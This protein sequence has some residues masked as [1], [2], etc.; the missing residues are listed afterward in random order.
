LTRQVALNNGFTNVESAYDQ[1]VMA[2]LHQAIQHVIF[3]IK[4]NRTYDQILGD[5]EIGNGDPDLTEFGE[6]VTPNL[7]SLARN[8]VTLD[9]FMDTAEVSYDG[10]LWTTS[11]QAPDVVEH[12]YPVA[13][14]YR[15][16]S[17]D[18]E[19][20][21]R[22]VNVAISNVAPGK[23]VPSPR[24]IADPLTPADPDVLPSQTDVAA[25][26]GPDNEIN[27]GY[28]WDAAIRAHL[29]VRNYGFFADL[30]RYQLNPATP[31]AA[32]LIPLLRNPFAT[33][34]TVMYPSNVKLT[35]FTD[36]YYRGFDNALPDFYR[37]QEW[38]RD[39]DARYVN[40]HHAGRSVEDLPALTLVRLMHD[41]TG[42]FVAS[43]AGPAAIDGVNTPDLEVADNDYAVG[44]LIQKIANSHYANNTLIFVIEDDSQDGG[45]HV[46]SHRSIAFVVGPYVKQGAL[47]STPYNTLNFLRTMEEVLG[48][49]QLNA[50]LHLP[51]ELNLNDA[52]ASPM[53]DL[54]R[55]DLLL[56]NQPPP[57]WNFS[58]SPAPILYNTSLP[59]PPMNVGMV[60]PKPEHNAKYW[61]RV[62]KGMD[63]SD[64][65]RVDPALFNRILWKGMMGDKPYPATSSGMDLRQ[66]R[67]ELLERYRLSLKQKA[68]RE[69][70]QTAAQAPQKGTD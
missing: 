66:N 8:F 9:N 52:L 63:F 13:Y 17:L 30:T 62:M 55:A 26:D 45:D 38:S 54:F 3:I 28:L 24:Q 46:D 34:T 59:L 6:A 60:V 27:T 23:G 67:R 51:P 22:G 69:P 11:G 65:D 42:N 19:G 16:T 31:L 68:D 35:P 37:Y 40:D 70:K 41:H 47:V 1:T 57:S 12:Q 48:L 49:P 43:S 33:G 15:G 18:S 44:L 14:A 4:E 53:T 20:F 32:Y 21:N 58:P 56:A 64:A 61:G 29:T 2:A 36:P 10:W 5:L 50:A 25:P 7:H 39:F